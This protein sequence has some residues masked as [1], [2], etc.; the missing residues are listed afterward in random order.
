MPATI[1]LDVG[2]QLRLHNTRGL[3][4]QK[5]FTAARLLL[6]LVFFIFGLNGFFH[7]I[8]QPPMEGPPAA[9]V[10]ALVASGYLMA[11]VK[12]VET[13]AGF[14]LLTGRQV[15][16][17][18]TLLAPVIVN[19]LL[20]HLYLAPAGL[21]L[22]IVITLLEIALAW[23]WREAFLPLFRVTQPVRVEKPAIAAHQHAHV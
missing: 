13:V 7:F 16:L 18:L 19:I 23:A 8:P 15:P 5:F 12:G 17:A 10:G 2:Q 11:L 3:I 21:A 1:Y 14:L 20:F 6:G 22:P 4:M 9:F